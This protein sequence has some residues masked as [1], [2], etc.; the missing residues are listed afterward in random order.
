MNKNI[1]AS[2]IAISIVLIAVVFINRVPGDLLSGEVFIDQETEF[3]MNSLVDCL[4]ERDVVIYGSEWC[5]FCKSLVRSFGGREVVDPIYVEC[6]ED[7]ERCDEEKLTSYV[8][9]IQIA[10]E[11][12]EGPRDPNDLGVQVECDF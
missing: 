9:E 7:Q 5:G 1:L 4:E 3:N 8:P 11:L 12:Y 6:T 10:G 2:I